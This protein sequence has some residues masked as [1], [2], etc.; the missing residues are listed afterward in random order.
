MPEIEQNELVMRIECNENIHV[1]E[2]RR[3]V[4]ELMKQADAQVK[5]HTAYVGMQDY[6]LN[7]GQ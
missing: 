1:D 2:N 4:D 7:G 3:R 5:E 6:I